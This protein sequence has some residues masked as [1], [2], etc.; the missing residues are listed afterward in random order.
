MD[1]P[2]PVTLRTL[3]ATFA[4]FLLL[5]MSLVGYGAFRW[6]A[7]GERGAGF[8]LAVGLLIA[9]AGLVGILWMGRNA[10]QDLESIRAVL[11]RISEG[12]LGARVPLTS[13]VRE[14]L[15]VARSVNGLGEANSSLVQ[16]LRDGALALEREVKRFHDAFNGI[17]RQA[18]RSR[19]ASATV[20]AAMEELGAGVGVIGRETDAVSA[21]AS[22]A[23]AL[24]RRLNEMSIDTSQAIGRQF[25][26]IQATGDRMGQAIASTGELER[27][28]EEIA[29]MAAAITDVA[30][31]LR[32]LALNASIE[33]VKAGEKGRGF[34]VVAQ[35]VKD[36]ADQAGGM[37]SRIQG[38][39][40]AVSA[41]TRRVAADMASSG[42]AMRGLQEE[43]Q[44]SVVTVEQQAA[45]SK[46]ARDRLDDTSRNLSE[47]SRTLSESRAALGEIG[48]TSQE[49]DMRAGATVSALAGLQTGL[50]DLDRLSRSFRTTVQDYRTAEPFFPWSDDL[51]VG[52]PRMDDQHRVLLRL[53]NRVADLGASGASGAAIRNILNQLVE[54]TRFH[55]ADEEKL[56]GSWGYP[57]LE[58]HHKTHEAFVAEVVGLLERT[59]S[60]E[61][62]DATSL[63]RVLKEWLV[64]HIQGTDKKY[65]AHF[66]QHT[67]GAGTTD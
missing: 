41:G 67:G 14:F 27:R 11:A 26:G 18:D 30:K 31:R 15:V 61:L 33:A 24:S 5:N 16:E 28:G 8:L 47:I 1:K 23:C 29:G 6:G 21:A 36:L 40:E 42:E 25:Q 2:T 37:A 19:E 20:A 44:R 32:L 13:R 54:Y 4:G 7:T 9:I 51:S 38:Q 64:R 45:L 46:E 12:D 50:S 63:L 58:A 53:I 55:F 49:L 62:I 10:L 39:V 17:R 22:E 56:M 60:G 3:P 59:G 43:G 48:Q 52:V 35:E 34:S 66:E 65:G 57:E